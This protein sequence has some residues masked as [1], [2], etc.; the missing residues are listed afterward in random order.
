MDS[1]GKQASCT[2]CFANWVTTNRIVAILHVLPRNLS[3]LS[4]MAVEVAK[5]VAVV[6]VELAA[7]TAA[8]IANVW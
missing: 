3:W 4:G 1:H 6:V 8:N 5:D 7:L 2:V